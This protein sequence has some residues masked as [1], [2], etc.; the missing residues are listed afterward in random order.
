MYT[1]IRLIQHNNIIVMYKNIRLIQHNN[2]NYN[3]YKY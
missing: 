3:A 1:N 2:N